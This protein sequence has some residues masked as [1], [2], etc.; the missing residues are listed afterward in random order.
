VKLSVQRQRLE[1]CGEIK[2]ICKEEVKSE[3]G[4]YRGG[5]LEMERKRHSKQRGIV[6][7]V[8][9]ME[10]LECRRGSCFLKY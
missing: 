4:L 10:S 1:V 5:M 3:L 2:K 6:C 9:E 7:T 8:L